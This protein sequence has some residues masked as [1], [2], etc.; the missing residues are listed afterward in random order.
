VKPGS[1][2]R[3]RDF[4]VGFRLRLDISTVTMTT[5]SSIVSHYS[6]YISTRSQAFLFY[7]RSAASKFELL[8]MSPGLAPSEMSKLS[9]HLPGTLMS[10]DIHIV[11]LDSALSST[12]F[13]GIKRRVVPTCE[14]FSYT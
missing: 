13:Q 3:R 1:S 6:Q 8:I 7:L 9:L 12:A 2:A 10:T 5:L 4:E 11:I 14:P